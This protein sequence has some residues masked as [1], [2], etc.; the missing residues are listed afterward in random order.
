MRRQLFSKR[1][2]FENPKKVNKVFVHHAFGEHLRKKRLALGLRQSDLGK[3]F[4]VHEH[5]VSDWE[6]GGRMPRLALYPAIIE[7]LGYE[8]FDIDTT[9]FGGKIK[10][11]RYRNGLSR[12][13]LGELFSVKGCAVRGWEIGAYTPFQIMY[14]EVLMLLENN[15]PLD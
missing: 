10:L 3:L 12:E 11:Y 2:T 5:A 9:T 6:M 15:K 13:E 8:W 14:D 4:G 7:F 1:A